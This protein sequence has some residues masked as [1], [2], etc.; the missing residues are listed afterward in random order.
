[1]RGGVITGREY[2]EWLNFWFDNANE[3]RTDRILLIGDS[4]ARDYRGPL[5]QLTNKPVDF[6]ATSTSISDDKFYKTLDLFFSYEEY[7][8][9]KAHIQIGVHG[10][11]GFGNAIQ[12]NS[13]EEFEK[14]YEKLITYVLK[15]IPDLTIAL[16]TSVVKLDN[17][18]ELDEK[19][20]NEIIK[21]NQ[22]A[23]KIAEKYKLE[24][25]DL[26]SL[27][28]SE[29]HRDRVHFPKEGSEKIAHKVAEVM[30]LI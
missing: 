8:Q 30:N 17:L 14:A 20:N 19:I 27:M 16:T 13:I 5:A 26:Y 7:R 21:R 23:K 4:V 24:V 9:Y 11:D 3:K 2:I 6:F 28:F 12:S 15:Y 10:I 18:S 22:I 1:M 25:N 29:P